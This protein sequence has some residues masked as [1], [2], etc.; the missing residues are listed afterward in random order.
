MDHPGH[1]QERLRDLGEAH[2]SQLPRIVEL[3]TRDAFAGRRQGRL[4]EPLQVSTIGKRLQ[5]I[6]LHVE[7]TVVDCRE[8]VAQGRQVLNGTD[9]FRGPRK[10]SAAGSPQM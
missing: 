6:L 9:R 4:R 7:V 2:Q 5:E 8:L 1:T 3:E 10:K